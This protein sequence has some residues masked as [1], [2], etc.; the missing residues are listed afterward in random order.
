MKRTNPKMAKQNKVSVYNGARDTQGVHVTVDAVIERIR[1][2]ERGLAEKT[3]ELNLLYKTDKSTYDAKKMDLPAVTWSGMFP[4]GER[5]GDSILQHSGLVVLD[6]DNDIDLDK[7]HAHLTEHP[8]VRFAFISPSMVGMKPVVRVSPVPMTVAEH[9]AAFDAVLKVF[10]EYADQDPTKLPAQRDPNRLCF[11]AHDPVAINCSD[12]EPVPWE[13]PASLPEPSSAPDPSPP[14]VQEAYETLK[15]L[16]ASDYPRWIE[17]GMA[18]KS[19]GLP[20]SVWEDWSKSAGNY[21]PGACEKKWASFKSAGVNWGSVVHWS[22]EAQGKHTKKTAAADVPVMPVD[23]SMQVPVFPDSE[24]E[25]F[26]GIFQDLYQAFA[27]SHVLTAPAIMA[28]GLALV[29]YAVGRRVIV[30]TSVLTSDV[31]FL[32]T[33]TLLIGRSDL[34]AKS[35][36]RE[37]LNRILQFVCHEKFYPI[38]DVQSIE[39][40]IRSMEVEQ[41]EYEETNPGAD[42]YGRKGYLEGSRLFVMLDEIATLFANARREGT[43]NLLSAINKFWKCPVV[44]RV[45]RAKGEQIV[46]YPVLSMWGN[47]TPDQ[48]VEYLTGLDMT[49]GTINRF[50]P[51]YVSPKVETVRHPHPII[52]HYDFVVK[53]L[54][55]IGDSREQRTLVFTEEADDARF[56]WFK[57]QREQQLQSEDDRGESRFHTTA[58]KIAGLFAVGENGLYDHAVKLSHWND[59]LAVTRYLIECYNYTFKQVGVS[60]L[61]KVEH[62]ILEVLNENGNEVAYG[63]L[64]RK[65]RTVDRKTRLEVIDSLQKS[66]EILTYEE[67][68]GGRV[69]KMVRRVGD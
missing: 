68:T 18:I 2:G 53:G 50:M 66:G 32:N 69:K 23:D 37:Q 25:H 8:N 13:L 41:K 49:G 51:F 15:P 33:Y 6:V 57:A 45:A 34:T 4:P 40:V 56:E 67:N 60:E 30:K 16:D 31:V 58:V 38:S 17:I 36:T 14:S 64:G 10:S 43:K 65:L 19:A 28:M 55:E 63:S 11:L 29:G 20:L 61:S 48:V 3:S 62:K 9:H 22:L 12:A 24:G 47:I 46:E 39:G 27:H 1:S 5:L 59:A 7:V 54:Q 44:E 42:F 35:D 52:E 26:P 21:E